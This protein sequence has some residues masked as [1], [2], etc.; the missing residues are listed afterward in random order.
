MP[1]HASSDPRPSPSSQ[2]CIN[3]RVHTITLSMC[4]H[5]ITL[6]R[7]GT[8]SG[9]VLEAGWYWKRDGTRSG[10][11]LEEGW[12]WKRDGTGNGMVHARPIR[13]MRSPYRPTAREGAIPSYKPPALPCH[14]PWSHRPKPPVQT[15]RCDVKTSGVPA[16]AAPSRVPC[17]P[18]TTHTQP[19][20]TT[21]RE[22]AI[23]SYKPP[24]RLAA[25]LSC[26]TPWSHRPKHTDAASPSI[27][28]LEAISLPQ[29]LATTPPDHGSIPRPSHAPP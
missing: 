13:P 20:P 19:L 14:A 10:M 8:R 25:R 3:N 16:L 23:P 5:T 15:R 11:V 24:A 29:R 9:M 12:Y 26:H 18:P 7:D 28:Y 1:I 17:A 21:A 22:G 2:P 27:R 6:K 4:V